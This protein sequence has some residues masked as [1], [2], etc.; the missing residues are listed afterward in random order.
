MSSTNLLDKVMNAIIP[1]LGPCTT[2][3]DIQY[4]RC[5]ALCIIKTNIQLDGA[6]TYA[7]NWGVL[8]NNSAEEFM[9]QFMNTFNR[10]VRWTY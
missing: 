1:T 5:E 8:V 3:D 9:M 2:E 4:A 10:E 7:K 6:Y